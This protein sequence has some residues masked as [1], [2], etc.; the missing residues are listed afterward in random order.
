MTV[1]QRLCKPAEAQVT[2]KGFA[3]REGFIDGMLTP[4]ISSDQDEKKI[5]CA[6]TVKEM[7]MTIVSATKVRNA[8]E[9][10]LEK[11][12]ATILSRTD[13][14]IQR[15]RIKSDHDLTKLHGVVCAA[16]ER[17]DIEAE[18]TL[19]REIDGANGKFSLFTIKTESGPERAIVRES[20]FSDEE[21]VSSTQTVLELQGIGRDSYPPQSGNVRMEDLLG[22][23]RKDLEARKIGFH[24]EREGGVNHFTYLEKGMESTFCVPAGIKGPELLN[25][26]ENK[27][28]DL[29]ATYGKPI[30]RQV[31]ETLSGSFRSPP[32]IENLADGALKR[33]AKTLHMLMDLDEAIIPQEYAAARQNVE[34]SEEFHAFKIG[35]TEGVV[36]HEEA[37]EYKRA[38]DEIDHPGHKMV[39]MIYKNMM[40]GERLITAEEADVLRTTL[41]FSEGGNHLPGKALETL[42]DAY[43]MISKEDV[44]GWDHAER[45]KRH[46]Q[47]AFH[48][49]KAVSSLGSHLKAVNS[50]GHDTSDT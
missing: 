20:I 42:A 49:R 45:E 23:E 41:R 5:F 12:A 1:E 48:I 10:L 32:G 26:I 29:H 34:G 31:A 24:G 47:M 11:E 14:T 2:T 25:V 43:G 19:Q 7:V 35:D 46:L 13:E 36:T 30:S 17:M 3:G 22:F 37:A 16:L 50:I 39:R 27:V 8:F 33:T 18:V 6:Q 38:F 21:P 4:R 28:L 44:S 15:K 9:N 40:D